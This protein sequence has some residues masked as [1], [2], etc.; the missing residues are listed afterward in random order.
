MESKTIDLYY[1]SG[2]GNT[3]LACETFAEEVKNYGFSV[4][5]ICIEKADP[6]N[7]NKD[8]IL[9]LAFPVVVCFCYPFILKF[10][11]ALPKVNG[12][13]AFLLATMG[14]SAWGMEGKLKD[15]LSKKG[16]TPVAAGTAIMPSNIFVIFNEEK[17]KIIRAQG[18]R[19]IRDF[20]SSFAMGDGVWKNGGLFSSFFYLFYRAA[21]ATW[22]IEFLQKFFRNK[23]T[24]DKCTKCGRC[25]ALCAVG[26]IT[27]K[28]GLPE[29]GVKCEYCMRCVS[30]CP[31]GA[32]KSKFIFKGEAYKAFYRPFH[33]V[34]NGIKI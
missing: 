1:F 5:L 20:A 14:G 16:F 23:L 28:E 2:T 25:A 11:N 8:N 22:K 10:I 34:N 29:F 24:A 21:T 7:I 6:A 19:R 9:G 17:N 33:K 18:L 26:N 31:A 13:K 15:I 30:Y 3:Y 4:N 32:I 12:T 27:F